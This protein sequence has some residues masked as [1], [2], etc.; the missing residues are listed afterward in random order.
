MKNEARGKSESIATNKNTSRHRHAFIS[1]LKTIGEFI[2]VNC[3][4]I[5]DAFCLS[6]SRF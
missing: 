1:E 4:P 6:F 3:V 2:V 5:A